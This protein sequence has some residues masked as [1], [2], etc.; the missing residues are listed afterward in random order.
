ML[1][2]LP[3]CFSRAPNTPELAQPRLSGVKRRSSPERGYKLGTFVPIWLVL[4]RCD[5]ANLG[6]FDLC[7]FALLKRALECFESPRLDSI[8]RSAGTG[9]LRKG[10]V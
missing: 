7:H 6:V 8:S 3:E 9:L 1:I 5:A 10:V 2:K 4:P